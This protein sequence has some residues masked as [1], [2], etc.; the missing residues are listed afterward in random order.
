MYYKD[1][2]YL[3]RGNGTKN[4]IFLH[5][6]GWDSSQ[7][8]AY[9]NL[10]LANYNVYL[11]D[12]PGF[13]KSDKDVVLSLNDYSICVDDF[14]K[15]NNIDNPL[16]IAHSFGGRIALKMSEK[17]YDY[18]TILISTPGFD[19]KSINVKFKL[20]L[21][22][23]F[24][25]KLPSKDYKNASFVQRQIMNKCI[26][27]TKSIDFSKIN[28]QIL[29][30]HGKYDKVVKPKVAKMMKRKIK[31]AS[32]VWIKGEHFPYLDEPIKLLKVINYYANL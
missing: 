24:N 14:I 10:F 22:R 12:L 4:I 19:L 6:W 21:N 13:G 23:L 28:K 1:I 7:F 11:I 3:K 8:L 20:L 16:I 2:Y 5:G 9:T 18:K 32:I 17:G 26:L 30:I 31:N 15:N 25:I 29:I 27:D